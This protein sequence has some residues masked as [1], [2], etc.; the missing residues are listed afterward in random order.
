MVYDEITEIRFHG[1]GGQGAVTAANILVGAAL[2]AGFYGQAIPFFGA[3]RRGAPVVA[4]A[5]ISKLPIRT[6][7]AVRTPSVVVVL[8]RRLSELVDVLEGLKVGGTVL[9][10]SPEAPDMR[11]AFR[12]CYVDAVKIALR[13][14]LVLS[15]WVLVNTPITGAL[16]KI[17]ELPIEAVEETIK[18]LIGG[19][20]GELNAAAARESFEGVRCVE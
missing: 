8:D 18:E 5:R 14:N 1:R 11:G 6:R 20:L 10:N 19:G 12:V 15:G 4:Y 2:K 13:H 7:S 16:A 17:I 9:V 3:E